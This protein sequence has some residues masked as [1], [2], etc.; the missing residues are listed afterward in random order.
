MNRTSAPRI[1][2]ESCAIN[3]TLPPL[4][5]P[6]WRDLT[7]KADLHSAFLQ[8]ASLGAVG[9]KS[10]PGA[11][12][13]G[14]AA[15]ILQRP[16]GL[17]PGQQAPALIANPQQHCLAAIRKQLHRQPITEE[18]LTNGKTGAPLMRCHHAM[19]K[20]LPTGHRLSSHRIQE[21][22]PVQPLMAMDIRQAAGHPTTAGIS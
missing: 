11:I 19:T 17:G 20:A 22:H 1:D 13:I 18:A 6:N 7:L 16:E 15:L 3:R 8:P 9:L 14:G 5:T 21:H 2:F 12:D 4:H 10:K